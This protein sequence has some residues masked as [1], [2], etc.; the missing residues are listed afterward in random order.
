MSSPRIAVLILAH[1]DPELINTLIRQVLEAPGE[2]GVFVHVDAKAEGVIDQ[3]IPDPRVQVLADRVDVRWADITQ[4]EAMLKLI[5]AALEQ[6]DYGV[7]TIKSGQDLATSPEWYTALSGSEFSCRKVDWNE[8]FAAW[9]RCRWPRITRQVYPKKAHPYRLI[10]AGLLALA[11]RGI[12]LFP[13]RRRLPEGWSVYHGTQW[14]TLSRSHAQLVMDC[15]EQQP[16]IL[17]FFADILSPEERLFQTVVMNSNPAAEVNPVKSH[18]EEFVGNHPRALGLQDLPAIRASGKPFARKF[19]PAFDSEV[20]R[21]LA[22]EA[23]AAK[24]L[25]TSTESA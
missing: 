14:V 24:T 7:L 6:P 12:R 17:Q 18:F 11:K 10:R 19:D 23:P 4:V 3:L 13:N 22:A 5:R 20:I 8:P 21:T 25:D 2:H 1:R 9:F 16:D 15:L